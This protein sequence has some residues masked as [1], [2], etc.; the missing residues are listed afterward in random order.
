MKITNKIL[1]EEFIRKHAD[2]RAAVNR[3]LETV[4]DHAF[5]DHNAL[6][7]IFPTADYV[8]N[9]RYVFN[10]KGNRYRMVILVVFAHGSMQIRF[11]GTHADYDK[12]REI[13]KI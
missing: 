4:E 11:C 1:L 8:G 7:A 13:K 2:A 9:L 12:I 3:W 10:I 5:S 6:K